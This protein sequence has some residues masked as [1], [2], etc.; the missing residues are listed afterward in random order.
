MTSIRAL[1]LI[2][3]IRSEFT[4]RNTKPKKK[5]TI[6]ELCSLFLP[7]P[8]LSSV[9]CR[10]IKGLEIWIV[11]MVSMVS[12]FSNPSFPHVHTHPPTFSTMVAATEDSL[13]ET[14]HALFAP[15]LSKIRHDRELVLSTEGDCTLTPM[16][17]IS[18]EG[19]S[20]LAPTVSDDIK[21]ID[22]SHPGLQGDDNP[23]RLPIKVHY[24]PPLFSSSPL[25]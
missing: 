8:S 9:T 19:I 16:F 5:K 10:L 11:S 2:I 24:V 22:L 23:L 7:S 15:Y 18:D 6:Q 25:L 14:L 1:A 12:S 21:L 4:N 20:D 13:R 3:V 17:A